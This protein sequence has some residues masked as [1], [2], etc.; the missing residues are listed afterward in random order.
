[1][2]RAKLVRR[3]SLDWK[4]KAMSDQGV[5]NSQ[6]I[7]KAAGVKP[8]VDNLI[9]ENDRLIAENDRL[10]KRC[11]SLTKEHADGLKKL[12]ELRKEV[13]TMKL[14]QNQTLA[15]LIHR[16][17]GPDTSRQAAEGI[18]PHLT[19]LHKE[20]LALIAKHP[21]RTAN[22]LSDIAGDRDPR[23]I[24]RRIPEL[25]RLERII[26]A[27]VRECSVT[28]KNAQTYKVNE[29][30]KKHEEDT[31]NQIGEEVGVEEEVD[32]EDDGEDFGDI[33]DDGYAEQV[34]EEAAEADGQA[35]GQGE[36]D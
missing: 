35:S 34:R 24:G 36:P 15:K 6:P 1:M 14:R 7:R 8:D 30:D 4:G 12:D 2:R 3:R 17:G 26:N 25:R 31:E 33:Y 21:G 28:G 20:V 19:D 10:L 11:E 9:A 5:F 29:G 22:E 27:G 13:Q 16:K 23:R 32:I 18:A